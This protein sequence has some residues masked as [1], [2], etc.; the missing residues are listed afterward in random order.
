MY[1]IVLLVLAASTPARCVAAEPQYAIVTAKSKTI[2]AVEQFRIHA[3]EVNV[4]IWAVFASQAPE[5]AGQSGTSTRLVPTGEPCTD[6]SPRHR[7]L[8]RAEVPADQPALW[9]ELDGHVEYR[10]TL[11]R[12]TLVRREEGKT[13][14]P[15]EQLSPAERELS[16]AETATL[17]F[18]SPIF[19]RWLQ[20]KGLHRPPRESEVDFGR[21]VFLAISHAYRYQYV[22]GINRH[23]SFVCQQHTADC[24]GLS[25][26]FA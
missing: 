3:P 11:H 22:D 5:L 18:S 8:L 2:R 14:P 17:D 26:L 15:A 10:A 12:R 7:A 16:L 9:H 19:Q 1:L 21:R 23:A 20:A 13:Y 24:G 25:S 4:R 6:L